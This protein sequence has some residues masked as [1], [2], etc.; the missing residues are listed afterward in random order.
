MINRDERLLFGH[1]WAVAAASLLLLIFESGKSTVADWMLVDSVR[2]FFGTLVVHLLFIPFWWFLVAVFTW[3]TSA[4]PFVI[5]FLIAE[6]FSIRNVW[7]YVV[8]GTLTGIIAT[9]VFTSRGG[10]FAILAVYERW[11]TD[12]PLVA[13]CGA[14]GGLVYWWKAGRFAG[15]VPTSSD[16]AIPK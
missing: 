9:P 14:F 3:L 4:I 1:L 16:S 8:C 10:T 5:S 2:A 7:Y 6:K 15:A 12:A 11:I 13:A